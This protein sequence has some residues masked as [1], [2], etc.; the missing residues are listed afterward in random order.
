MFFF[1]F[2]SRRRHT[3]SCLV[4][5]L[6]DV[7]KR[8]LY[9]ILKKQP[10]FSLHPKFLSLKKEILLPVTTLGLP[11]ACSTLLMSISSM[12]SNR[13]MMGYGPVALAAQGVAGKIGML[14]SMLAMGICM[15]MQLSLIHI[16][17]PTRLG[18]IS[19]AVFCL[20]KKNESEI[21]PA[22]LLC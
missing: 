10:A 20:K 2:S 11:L 4:S 7:Y 22:H 3:R 12:I 17:E 14:L 13:L 9:Y 1:F 5:W 21:Y 6:G 18:M 15:G 8:Q 16:S 19:Y